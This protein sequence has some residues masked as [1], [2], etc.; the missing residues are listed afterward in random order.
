MGVWHTFSQLFRPNRISAFFAKTCRFQAIFEKKIFIFLQKILGHD[1][2]FL[3]LMMLEMKLYFPKKWNKNK[4][5]Y[6]I[7]TSL[8]HCCTCIYIFHCF[9]IFFVTSQSWYCTWVR[10]EPWYKVKQRFLNF[11][12][13]YN[14]A[15]SEN[16]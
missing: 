2:I 7:V 6:P 8:S 12:Q 9:T 1:V 16:I 10:F 5:K 3:I 14:V 15:S 11:P 4:I 13:R